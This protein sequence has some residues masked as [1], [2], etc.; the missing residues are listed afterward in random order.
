MKSGNILYLH[1]FS[2]AFRTVPNLP[3]ME[4]KICGTLKKL[5]IENLNLAFKI[6]LDLSLHQVRHIQH[7]FRVHWRIC[8][9]SQLT[10]V[11]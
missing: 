6:N 2:R 4:K 9:T 1:T 3:T 11:P 7:S 5:D 8:T 10:A